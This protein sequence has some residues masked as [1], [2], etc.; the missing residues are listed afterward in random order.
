[1]SRYDELQGKT[2]VIGLSWDVVVAAEIMEV[3]EEGLWVL[4]RPGQVGIL[5]DGLH[6]A[7]PVKEIAHAMKKA[8]YFIPRDQIRYVLTDSE[9][10]QSFVVS[11]PEAIPSDG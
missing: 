2:A 10:P 6:L 7:G 11:S 5:P 9:D 8:R 1:M 3:A 4:L